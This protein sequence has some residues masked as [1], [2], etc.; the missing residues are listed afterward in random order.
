MAYD[1]Q[2]T[3]VL[4]SVLAIAMLVCATRLALVIA[5]PMDATAFGDRARRR[6]PR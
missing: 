2:R 5:G 6:R 1:L 4:L 3:G